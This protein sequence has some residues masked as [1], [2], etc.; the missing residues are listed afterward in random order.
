MKYR[1]Y[2]SEAQEDRQSV[3][4]AAVSFTG[5]NLV[6]GFNLLLIVDGLFKGNF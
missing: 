3:V 6:F 2:Y 1:L 5:D 4:D